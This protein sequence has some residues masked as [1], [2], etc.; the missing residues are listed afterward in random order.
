[1]SNNRFNDH[2]KQRI[3]IDKLS[4]ADQEKHDNQLLKASLDFK[5]TPIKVMFNDEDAAICSEF[6]SFMKKYGFPD[7][8]KL[9]LETR[10]PKTILTNSEM[11]NGSWSYK[12]SQK[13]INSVKW[14]TLWSGIGY[15]IG[16][17][18]YPNLPYIY[19]DNISRV[20]LCSD[21]KFRCSVAYPIYN[22]GQSYTSGIGTIPVKYI[23][24]LR[25]SIGKFVDSNV[26]LNTKIFSV[27][28]LDTLLKSISESAIIG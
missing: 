25:F 3:K 27:S 16:V 9:T 7:S 19:E 20:Y 4:A 6:I 8:E 24:N 13:I 18:D 28:N 5:G 1:M 15:Q 26:D 22:D 10:V 11:K 14:K 21:L 17:I 2:I 12:A 23:T